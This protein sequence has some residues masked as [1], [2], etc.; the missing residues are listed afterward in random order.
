MET[1]SPERDLWG[2][3]MGDLADAYIV[4]CNE[5]EKR[6][7]IGAKGKIKGLLTDSTMVVNVKFQPQYTK[8]SYHRFIFTTNEPEPMNTAE[9]DRRFF[10]IRS[11]DEFVGNAEY[12][13]Y[14]RKIIEDVDVQKTFMN[15]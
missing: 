15:T 2:P 11:S 12:H 3:Y 14:F 5:I 1:T 13:A 9:G 10:F 4:N 7:L 8:N 6:Y